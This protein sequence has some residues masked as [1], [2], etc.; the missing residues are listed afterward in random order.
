MNFQSS[1]GKH[2]DP[3]HLEAYTAECRLVCRITSKELPRENCNSAGWIFKITDQFYQTTL[4][5]LQFPN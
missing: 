3:I 4:A 2:F 5:S 1:S